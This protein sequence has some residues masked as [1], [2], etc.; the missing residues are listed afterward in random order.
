MA[1]LA[2]MRAIEL[3]NRTMYPSLEVRPNSGRCAKLAVRL[4]QIFAQCKSNFALHN[5]L[6]HDCLIFRTFHLTAFHLM[7]FR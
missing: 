7:A 2:Q 4:R 6:W 1:Q 3:D 5:P